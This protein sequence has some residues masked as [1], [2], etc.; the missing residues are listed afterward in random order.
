MVATKAEQRPVVTTGPAPRR[1]A[2]A[3]T[4]PGHP[5]TIDGT[6]AALVALQPDAPVLL[7]SL[8]E[9][10]EAL[11]AKRNR[12]ADVARQLAGYLAWNLQ[13]VPRLVALLTPPPVNPNAAVALI[14][15]DGDAG[16]VPWR[17]LGDP[18]L[19]GSELPLDQ[20]VRCVGGTS[21]PFGMPYHVD[22]A[23]YVPWWPKVGSTLGAAGIRLAE[24][25]DALWDLTEP[26]LDEV[27]TRLVTTPADPNAPW[28]T[29][30][31]RPV[32]PN[33]GRLS[34]CPPRDPL[35]QLIWYLTTRR[36][37]WQNAKNIR[38]AWLALS[39]ART[40]SLRR[41]QQLRETA[42][43]YRWW[44]RRLDDLAARIV[45]PWA[46]SIHTSRQALTALAQSEGF[47]MPSTLTT[48][49]AVTDL[50]AA[51]RTAITAGTGGRIDVGESEIAF[52]WAVGLPATLLSYVNSAPASARHIPTWQVKSSSTGAAIVAE[53]GAKSQTTTVTEDG[54]DLSKYVGGAQLS[55]EQ[56]QF[57][58][59]IE[60]AISSS[61]VTDLLRGAER[62]LAAALVASAGLVIADAADLASGVL[63]AKAS[64]PSANVLVLSP[65]DFVTLFSAQGTG[66]YLNFSSP[67]AGPGNYL[68]LTPCVVPSMT[69]GTVVVADGRG[70]TEWEVK[71]APLVAVDCYT[72]LRNNKINIYMETWAGPQVSSPGS[73]AAVTVTAGP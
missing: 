47:P 38:A 34:R 59:N 70:I 11:P 37:L 10:T 24:A 16:P 65:A 5:E 53:G 73:V 67:E 30:H 17:S 18:P 72:E 32:P 52:P 43:N 60:Q 28:G 51:I 48:P 8:R 62:D 66:G 19:T 29:L 21:K 63:Q 50:A 2:T 42:D 33:A 14:A 7:A 49:A 61:L 9:W 31:S 44:A 3:A 68:G 55:T 26:L 56:A 46:A 41:R 35:D 12:A 54:L 57:V 27:G 20:V 40:V 64:I 4:W 1:A 22:T 23:G 58:S 45:Q 15:P 25:P 71:G 69:A 6:R 13:A 36:L 39:E